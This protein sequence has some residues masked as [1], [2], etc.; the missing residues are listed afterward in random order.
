MKYDL[1][2][3][4][5]PMKDFDIDM[6]MSNTIQVKEGEQG[7]NKIYSVEDHEHDYYGIQTKYPPMKTSFGG[8]SSGDLDFF[9]APFVYWKIDFHGYIVDF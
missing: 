7:L 2:K 3:H 5:Q 1:D 9:V 8:D 6:K 4:S